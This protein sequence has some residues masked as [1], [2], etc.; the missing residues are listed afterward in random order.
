MTNRKV[1]TRVRNKETK[2]EGNVVDI[3]S[4]Q[5]T[6]EYDDGTFGFLMFKWLKVDWEIIK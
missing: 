1:F 4:S 6:V 3:L 5:I 2:Q